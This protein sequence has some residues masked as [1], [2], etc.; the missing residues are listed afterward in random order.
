MIERKHVE[1]EDRGDILIYALSTCGWCRK[2]KNHLKEL[3]IAF[4]YIDVDLLQGEESE[5]VMNTVRRFNEK[6]SFPTIVI[7]GKHCVVGYDIDKVREI[8]E[9]E[10]K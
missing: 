10:S 7:N 9:N 2:T 5:E 1:G 4:D 8:L 3:G 6:G